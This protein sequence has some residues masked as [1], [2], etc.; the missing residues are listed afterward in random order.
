MKKY[1]KIFFNFF[2]LNAASTLVIVNTFSFVV[3]GLLSWGTAI[4]LPTNDLK[5]L[6]LFNSI[7]FLP[8]S[9]VSP[10]EQTFAR[11]KSDQQGYTPSFHWTSLLMLVMPAT[12]VCI[13]CITLGL[14]EE[15]NSEKS[16]F[17][18]LFAIQI[19]FSIARG[20]LTSLMKYQAIYRGVLLEAVIRLVFSV[21]GL[22]NSSLT[23]MLYSQLI[24]M[25][26]A[27]VFL[28]QKSKEFYSLKSG[29]FSV[30]EMAR[31]SN[32]WL[33]LLSL[34]TAL[35]S[36]ALPSALNFLGAYQ[37]TDR[38]F[39]A[40]MALLPI[41][42]F[43]LILFSMFQIL[44]IPYFSSD[45]TTPKRLESNRL[46][47]RLIG[48]AFV[49]YFLLSFA[50]EQFFRT[51]AFVGRSNI[52]LFFFAYVLISFINFRTYQSISEHSEKRICTLWFAYLSLFFLPI[53]MFGDQFH[54]LSSIGLLLT[55][56]SLLMSVVLM[57]GGVKRWLVYQ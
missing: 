23:L 33:L 13:V 49:G 50:L 20:F 18:A 30:L 57:I 15:S 52:F 2:P 25:F 36:V 16:I 32:L 12:L 11:V 1:Y 42:R 45:K 47:I 8:M 3:T 9:L 24:A 41:L 10:I 35:P 5:T 53:W 4:Y 28:L 37:P 26:M 22:L 17:F 34:F 43:P 48:S 38:Q 29:E 40:A 39:L 31:T 51:F 46:W 14:R 44:L 19:I 55:L 54:S 27:T 21:I 7:L 6:I 56:S